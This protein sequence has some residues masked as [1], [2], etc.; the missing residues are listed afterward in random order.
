MIY[1]PGFFFACIDKYDKLSSFRITWVRSWPFMTRTRVMYI[2]FMPCILSLP[3]LPTVRRGKLSVGIQVGLSFAPWG[4]LRHAEAALTPKILG[5][6][7]TDIAIHAVYTLC[8]GR[9]NDCSFARGRRAHNWY[10]Y[11]RYIQNS[12]ALLQQ[13]SSYTCRTMIMKIMKT[14]IIMVMRTF[15]KI[16]TY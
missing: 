3:N 7:R 2:G 11:R 14:M 15:H 9:K 16:P 8:S 12:S 13:H 6:A 5:C 10:L 1:L 4:S